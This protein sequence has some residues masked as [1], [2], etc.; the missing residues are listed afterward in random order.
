MA[1]RAGEAADGAAKPAQ[2]RIAQLAAENERLKLLVTAKQNCEPSRCGYLCKYRPF[3]TGLFSG[4]WELRFFT[5]NG[6]ALQYYKNE[7]ATTDHPRGHVDVAGCIVEVEG[8]KK[9]RFWTFGVVDRGGIS[10]LRMST[11]DEH[12][13]DAWVKALMAAGC[14][15]RTLSGPCRTRSPLRSADVRWRGDLRQQHATGT[16]RST[17]EDLS[18]RW[19]NGVGRGGEAEIVE[20]AAGHAA[21]DAR[22]MTDMV[23]RAR[24]RDYTSD[25][26]ASEAGALPRPQPPPVERTMVR[27]TGSTP[28]HVESRPSMLSSNR[29]ALQQ[30][31][32]LLNLMMLILV[33]AN[34]RLIMEN[35]LKYGVLTNPTAWIGFALPRGNL[36]LLLCWPSLAAFATAALG[37]ELLGNARLKAEK[38]AS[39]AKKKKDVRPSDARR[40]AARMGRQ[41]EAVLFA[42]N[43]ANLTAALGVPCAVVELTHAEAV[44]GFV[45]T[46]FTVV[47]WMKLVS[48]AHCNYDLRSRRRAADQRQHE[49]RAPDA[50]ADEAMSGGGG[51]AYPRNL[52]AS[53]L[54]Y[55]L[56]VP[57][58]I[59]QPSYPRSMRFR[60]RWLFFGIGKLVVV[61]GVALMITEQYLQPTIANS[62]VPLRELNWPH[63]IERVLKLSLPTLYGW[64]LIFYALFHLWL[65]IVAEVTGFGDREFYKDW[66]NSDTTGTYWK[67]WNMPVHKWM[68]RHV[69]FPALHAGV[70]RMWAGTLVFAV[71]ATFHELLVGLPLHMVRC[72]AFVGVMSQVPLMYLTEYLKRKV[73]SD[74]VGNFIFWVTFCVIGQPISI[75]LY[76]HD[77]LLINRPEWLPPA[78]GGRGVNATLAFAPPT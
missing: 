65:N 22:A 20:R 38:K 68:L 32:G 29:I 49:R 74:Q 27:M 50:D 42:L 64:L 34:A 19:V 16:P 6:S 61:A 33:C 13:A 63:M 40:L 5:L 28:L 18:L 75:I 12:A 71:S 58:L 76:Y 47:L 8:Q 70:P 23:R 52:T 59:Y 56:V 54:A 10:L 9:G 37:I 44:P 14:E 53:N 48:F 45:V 2:A 67:R 4:Q 55:F 41:T 31:S 7:K 21:A 1:A 62:L 39:M 30:H 25:S 51:V 24:G 69:Y 26:G 78:V 11:A 57:T 17:P 73:K 72:W 60:G 3:T 77:W 43:A 35:L 15:M 66:W 46:I 36:P